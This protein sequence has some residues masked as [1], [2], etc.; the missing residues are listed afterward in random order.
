MIQKV[1]SVFDSKL[2]AFGRPWF[3]MRDASAIR[4]FSDAVNDSSNPLN[5]WNKHPEDFHLFVIGQFDDQLGVLM[6]ETP[7]SIVTAASLHGAPP[8]KIFS[9]VINGKS[10]VKTP[11]GDEIDLTLSNPPK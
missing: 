10:P 1:Y 8:S 7:V 11:N 9:E 6:P 3:S 2:A 4:E 5:Q